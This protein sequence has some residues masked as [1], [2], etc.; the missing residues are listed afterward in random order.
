M[1]KEKIIVANAFSL[2]MVNEFPSSLKM[3]EITTADFNE[4]IKS[5][6][7]ISAVGHQDTATLLGVPCNRINVSID[8]ETTLVVAQ[9]V[10][11]RLPEGST[12]LPEGFSFKFIKV[13]LEGKDEDFLII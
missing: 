7:F 12:T 2:Q 13:E 4:V 9:L 11:G 6:N 5:G 8:K 1:T 10:G 3:E